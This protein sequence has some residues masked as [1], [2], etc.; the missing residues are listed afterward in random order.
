MAR[1]LSREEIYKLSPEELVEYHN[2]MNRKLVDDAPGAIRPRLEA[3]LFYIEMECSFIEDL[4]LRTVTANKK[5]VVAMM[6]FRDEVDSEIDN[7]FFEDNDGD[8]K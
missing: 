2:A 3:I 4:I 6:E 1:Y 5:L 7:I 8:D